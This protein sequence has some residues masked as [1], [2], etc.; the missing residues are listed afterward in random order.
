[1]GF[2]FAGFAD[3]PSFLRTGIGTTINFSDQV[4]TGN[5]EANLGSTAR[6]T[7]GTSGD[8]V[9]PETFKSTGSGIWSNDLRT[10]VNI[11]ILLSIDA[12]GCRTG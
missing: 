7:S 1:M 3:A 4:H 9:L 5:T 6:R 8:S 11:E 12:T 2:H 10:N